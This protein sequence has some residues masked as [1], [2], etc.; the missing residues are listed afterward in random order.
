M[1]RV[2]PEIIG[3]SVPIYH[4][5]ENFTIST[6]SQKWTRVA[7]NSSVVEKHDDNFFHVQIKT[8]DGEK[9]NQTNFI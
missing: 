9:Y 7:L 5:K 2:N 1:L 6:F 8:N 4:K 3:L